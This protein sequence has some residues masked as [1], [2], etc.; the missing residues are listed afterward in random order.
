VIRRVDHGPS[1]RD[2]APRHVRQALA[3]S[4]AGSSVEVAGDLSY[5]LALFS[6]AERHRTGGPFLSASWK[7]HDPLPPTGPATLAT[8]G[9]ARDG[10]PIDMAAGSGGGQPAPVGLAQR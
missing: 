6:M 5:C 8:L 10:R 7:G 2:P 3:S 1:Q 9:L 4:I